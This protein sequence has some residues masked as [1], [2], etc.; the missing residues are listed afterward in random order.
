MEEK[1]EDLP[2]ETP[3]EQIPEEEKPKYTPRPAWQVWLARIGLVI[4]VILVL[5]YYF[6]MMRGNG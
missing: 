1:F 5:L 3:A 6:N 4:F 2:E